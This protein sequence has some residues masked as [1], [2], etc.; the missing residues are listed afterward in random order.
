MTSNNKIIELK[1]VWVSFEDQVVLEDINLSIRKEDFLGIIGPNGAGKTTLL[2]LIL[3]LIQ[4]DRGE[5]LVL[6][7]QPKDARKFIGYVPQTTVFDKEFP[8]NVWEVVLLGRLNQ[9]GWLRRFNPKDKKLAEEALKT[10]GMWHLKD[11]QIGQLSGGQRQRVFIARALTQN[12]KLLILDEPTASVDKPMQVGVYDLLEELKKEMTII[13]VSH[14]IGAV[15]SFVNKIACLNRKLFYHDSKEITAEHLE[16]VYE[17][18]V[19]LIA[20]GVPHRI[21]KEHKHP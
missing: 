15:A 19:D 17:C 13:L 2:K 8:I 1:N 11:K 16:V 5:V 18:P 4:P 9:V 12:P 7:R 3:G 21:L 20:H 10:V 6:G 14:D